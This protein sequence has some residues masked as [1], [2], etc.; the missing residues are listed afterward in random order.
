MK[1]VT[2][3]D[4]LEAKGKSKLSQINV[5]TVDNARACEAAGI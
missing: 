5:H 1:K 4:L 2:V 3:K